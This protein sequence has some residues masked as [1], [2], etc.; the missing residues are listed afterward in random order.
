MVIRAVPALRSCGRSASQDGVG[1]QEPEL[2]LCP[3]VA[4][5]SVFIP[6]QHGASSLGS[7][8]LSP[9]AGLSLFAIST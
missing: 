4:D 9:L 8:R 5:L 3:A 2:G 1:T 6:V 7:R